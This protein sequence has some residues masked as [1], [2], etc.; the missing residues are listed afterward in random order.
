MVSQSNVV[1]PGVMQGGR[2]AGR[3]SAL[4]R[5]IR[6]NRIISLASVAVVIALWQWGA[7]HVSG[8]LLPSPAEVLDRFVDPKW[9]A[10]L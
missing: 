6:D 10:A 3:P 5:V 1:S 2:P 4:A 7:G 8:F 9:L